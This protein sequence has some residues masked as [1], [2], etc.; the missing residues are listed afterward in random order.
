MRYLCLARLYNL[1]SSADLDRQ[2]QQLM[3]ALD[4]HHTPVEQVT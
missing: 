3:A 2:A 1:A 4:I